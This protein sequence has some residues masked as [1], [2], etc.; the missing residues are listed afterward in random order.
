MKEKDFL[1]IAL[2]NLI[3][4]ANIN[5]V[6]F[7]NE[8][9]EVDGQIQLTYDDQIFRFNVE[10]RNELIPGRP[11]WGACPAMLAY[12]PMQPTWP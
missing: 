8:R 11:C 12:F 10:I 1:H 9:F 3:K 7:E 4:T 5:A 6:W 2:E